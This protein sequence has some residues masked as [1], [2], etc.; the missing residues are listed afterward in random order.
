MYRLMRKLKYPK[1]TLKDWSKR[2]MGNP[3]DKIKQNSHK[4]NYVESKLC[5][6]P[7][8]IRLNSW[9]QRLLRQ[10]ERLLLFHQKYW[11]QLARKKWL[12]QGDHNTHFLQANIKARIH[13]TS[14]MQLKDECGIWI[15]DPYLISAKFIKYFTQRFTSSYPQARTL[16]DLG[17]PKLLTDEDNYLLTLPPTLEEVRLALFSMDSNKTPGPDGFGAG[18]FKTYW[19]ILKS[20]LF[21]SVA[22]FFRNVNY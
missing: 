7:D 4:L 8:S 15:K 17:L 18:F 3:I 14:I 13:R 21:D 5:H 6:N 22:E 16:S 2:S 20:N 19:H 9:M 10:R 1:L 12:I 11:G